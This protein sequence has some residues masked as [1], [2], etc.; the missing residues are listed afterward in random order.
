MNDR[1]SSGTGLR[2]NPGIWFFRRLLQAIVTLFLLSILTFGLLRLAP[3][4]PF[5]GEKALPPDVIRNIEARY[6]LGEPVPRQFADWLRDVLRADLRESF[7]YLDR[8]VVEIISEGLPAS[9]GLGGGALALSLALGIPLGLHSARRR[10]TASDRLITSVVVSGL[11]LP[12]YLVASIL[13]LVFA[14]QLE[15]LPPALWDEPGSWILPLTTLALRPLAMVTRLVRASALDQYSQDYI[16]TALAKGADE[17]RVLYRHV[18]ANSLL[19]VVALIGPLAANLL[20]GSFLVE[21]VFQIPGIGRHFVSAVI[22]RDYPLVMGM[23]LIYGAFLL[24]S[25]LIS[26]LLLASVDPRIRVG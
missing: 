12:S 4:G 11:N 25:N 23:A 9:A 20:T 1:A 17:R 16:R 21:T 18:L 19:P 22:N 13:V 7:V 3:G 5:D 2:D 8:P 15:W 26:D 14:L 24:L 10:G 6:G